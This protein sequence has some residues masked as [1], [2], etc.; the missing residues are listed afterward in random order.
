MT[1]FK[2]LIAT[3]LAWLGSGANWATLRA[4]VTELLKSAFVKTILLQ[5]FGSVVSG[6]YKAWIAKIIVEYAFDTLALPIIQLSFRK[7][8]Y[9]YYRVHGDI[10]F[11]R[12]EE[13]KNDNN[14]K[15]YD[16]AVDSLFR[17]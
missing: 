16:D 2:G 17:S 1:W 12:I 6:K 13:A 7:M 4:L 3:A 8:G 11:K 14:M 10:L 15:A 9:V 5:I